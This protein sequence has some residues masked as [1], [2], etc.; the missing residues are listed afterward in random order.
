MATYLTPHVPEKKTYELL[1]PDTYNAS[2]D[3][4]E[5]DT[6]KNYNDPN[7]TEDYMK[8]TFNITEPGYEDRKIWA[9]ATPSL[10]PGSTGLSASTLYSILSAVNRKEYSEEE[11]KAITAANINELEGKTLRLIIKQARNRKGEMKNKIDGYLPSKE[12][13]TPEER[14]NEQLADIPSVESEAPGSF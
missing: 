6:R 11:S 9:N 3:K 4:I 5:D 2:I 10:F 7:I 1:P 8:F 14:A 13:M 12:N